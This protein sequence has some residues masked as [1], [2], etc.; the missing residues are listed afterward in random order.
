MCAVTINTSGALLSKSIKIA[1][2]TKGQRMHNAPMKAQAV[3]KACPTK[4]ANK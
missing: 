4:E 2:S 1:D 3:G